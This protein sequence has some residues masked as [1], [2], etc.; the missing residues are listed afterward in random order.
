[1]KK[2]IIFLLT[3]SC[4]AIV[5]ESCTKVPLTGRRQFKLL[6]SSMLGSMSLSSYQQVLKESQVIKSGPDAQMVKRVGKN[7]SAAVTDF[8]V[9]HKQAKRLKEFQW[10]FNLIDEDVANAWAMPGGKVAF[11]TGILPYTETETGM[12][13]VM[14]HEIAHAVARHGNERMSWGLAQQLGGIGLAIAMRDKPAETQEIFMNAYGV[15]SQVGLMLPFSRKHESEADEMGLVFMAMAGYPPDEAVNFW[16]RMAKS[17]GQQ[18]PEFIS[19]HPSHDTRIKNLREYL[20]RAKK[21]YNPAKKQ[22]TADQ[23]ST[24]KK[25]NTKKVPNKNTN[26]NKTNNPTGTKTKTGGSSRGGSGSGS[27]TKTNTGGDSGGYKKIPD[28]SSSGSSTGSSTSSGS[29][30]TTTKKGSTRVK[31]RPK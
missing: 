7:L 17:G 11:Y 8:M 12:A 16:T 25:S 14:G 26:T 13:V 18:P 19:T 24:Y 30:G 29:T 4:A 3:I 9:K 31:V 27:G 1:M 22:P 23:K 10:E 20:P 15:G 21:Y 6:P 5:L 2:L 28:R